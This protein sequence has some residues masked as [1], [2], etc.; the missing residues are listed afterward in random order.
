MVT[1]FISVILCVNSSLV[2]FSGEKPSDP[3][4]YAG[5]CDSVPELNKAILLYV[6]SK[7]GKKVG[8]GECWDLASESLKSINAT[9]DGAYKYGRKIDP[10]KECVFP[11]DIVQ[12]EG[13]KLKYVKD[14]LEYTEKMLHHTAI[15]HTVKGAG[16]YEL[17]H[18]NTAYSG[19]KVGLSDLDFS[20]LTKGKF[21]IYR[22]TK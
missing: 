22:P 7:M 2:H 5:T 3:A 17:A 11:G 19:R 1:V 16:L 12:F 4:F 9:W 20:T 6:D 21:F 18:Q 10:E 8:R 15:I 14:G 13:V